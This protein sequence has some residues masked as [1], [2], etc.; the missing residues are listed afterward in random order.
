VN[1]SQE[2]ARSALEAAGL[3]HEI[4]VVPGVDHAFFNDTGQRYSADAAAEVYQ[5]MLAWFAQ[6]LA[7]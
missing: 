4:S 7:G 2:T 3:V 5:A 6:H 1:A